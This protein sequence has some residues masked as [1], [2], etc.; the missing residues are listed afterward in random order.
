MAEPY[1]L[2]NFSTIFTNHLPNTLFGKSI[3]WLFCVC[4][5]ES[6]LKYFIWGVLKTVLHM[7]RVLYII[8]MTLT[9]IIKCNVMV[10]RPTNHMISTCDHSHDPDTWPTNFILTSSH[11]QYHHPCHH[12][13]VMTIS[14]S[15]ICH[16]TTTS[17]HHYGTRR[18]S[19]KNLVWA[20]SGM[21]WR[22]T[23]KTISRSMPVL[24]TVGGG[25]IEGSASNATAEAW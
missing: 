18:P 25:L 7:L 2:L 6:N 8:K 17:P 11:H 12:F 13:H 5:I 4:Y 23:R 19:S 15:L 16:T 3:K 14:G 9:F 20:S 22:P 1:N 24:E 21:L 10:T